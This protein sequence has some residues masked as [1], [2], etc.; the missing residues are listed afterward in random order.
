MVRSITNEIFGFKGLNFSLPVGTKNSFI[1]FWGQDV[2]T[3][4]VCF[5]PFTGQ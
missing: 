2:L 3:C 4:F 1:R 5:D